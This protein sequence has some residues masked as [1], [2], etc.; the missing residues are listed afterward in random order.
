MAARRIK[1]CRY[2]ASSQFSYL[3]IRNNSTAIPGPK[4]YPIIGCL[5]TL[6][7]DKDFDKTKIFAYFQKLFRLYGPIVKVDFP[8]QPTMIILQQPE[9]VR[10][11]FHL[12]NKN[13]VRISMLAL[14]K[15]KYSNPYF[16]KKAGIAVEQ[17]DEWWRV[18][19]QVQVPMMKP[20]NIGWYI[21]YMDQITLEFIDRVSKLRDDAGEVSVDFLE[22][23]HNWALENVCF[24]AL[25]QR[26]G[27]FNDESRMDIKCKEIKDAANTYLKSIF[28]IESK[29]LWKFY[30]TKDYRQMVDSLKILTRV[31]D[32]AL[33]EAE[34]NLAEKR[35]NIQ[36]DDLTL[37][38]HLLLESTLSRKD[39][40][41]F[42]LDIIPG[43][44]STTSDNVAVI[45]YL[46]AKNP[47]AQAKLQEEIDRV[48]GNGKGYITQNQYAQLS[49]TRAVF[50]EAN[51]VMPPMFGPLRQL[52][53]DI[54]IQGYT[55]RKGWNLLLLHGLLGWE[56]SLFPKADQFLPERW[57]R[58]RPLGPIDPFVVLPFTH[59]KRMCIGRRVAEQAIYIIMARVLHKYNLEWRHEDM[60][61]DYKIIFT[62]RGPL[63]FTLIDRN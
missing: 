36:K 45:L 9:D 7:S 43:G 32:Q 33:R 57:L 37:T 42:M 31:I 60:V 50:K 52:Q 35:G 14:K 63:K 48:L 25:N 54:Q 12:T 24:V 11:A 55:L 47:A 17:G 4:S 22:E 39:I 56:E 23:I 3:H 59:G 29:K 51:R 18:R 16:E 34:R 1:L 15:A 5:P 40:A 38:D 26:I 20:R 13:P 62:P 49:F 58:D 28:A 21:K 2:L 61:R 46:L 41:S 6:L 53:E 30:P 27:C 8:G 44:T 10:M 19:S